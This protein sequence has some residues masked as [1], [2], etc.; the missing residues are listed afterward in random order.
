MDRN[1]T[2]IPMTNPTPS[3]LYDFRSDTTTHPTPEMR[4]AMAEAPVGDDVHGE[5][6]TI[7][8]LQDLAAEMLGK[9]AALF[10][11]S[12]TMGNLAAILTHCNRGDE[13]IMGHLSHTFLFEAGGC[14]ALGGVNPHLLQNQPDGT[15][16]LDEIQAAIRDIRDVHHPISKLIILENTHNWTGGMP[17]TVQYTRCVGDLAHENGLLLH[18]DGA[19]I[20]NAAAALNV[21]V[22]ELAAPADTVTFCLSKGLGAPAGSL[23]C[24]PRDF[25]TRA[26][27]IRKQLGGGMRQVGILAA[28]GIIGLEVMSKRLPEDHQRAKTLSAGLKRIKGLE[29]EK[30]Q[31]ATNIVF[32]RLSKDSRFTSFDVAAEMEK[33]G[34]LIDTDGPRRM[35]LVTHYEI[36]DEAVAAALNGFQEI[37]K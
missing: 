33:R 25:I 8:R 22:S 16:N 13:A 31:P 35:R 1:D 20:F 14:A 18:I 19:R 2:I 21:P 9:E 4:Q 28:A 32:F 34:V 36:N 10:V 11:P 3:P 26:T 7:N 17:L 23:L 5:D 29:V 6:P 27:R 30:D 12:G 37:F 15:M 24:G